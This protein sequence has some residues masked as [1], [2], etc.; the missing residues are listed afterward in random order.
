MNSTARTLQYVIVT[1]N[2][3]QIKYLDYYNDKV[4]S[5]PHFNTTTLTKGFNAVQVYIGIGNFDLQDMLSTSTGTTLIP[6]VN[7]IGVIN[8]YRRRVFSSTKLSLWGIF[9]SYSQIMATEMAIYGLTLFVQWLSE[10]LKTVEDYRDK[11]IFAGFATV[12]G[13][14]AFLAGIFGAI[15]GTSIIKIVFAIKPLSVY[16]LAHWL[17]KPA[18]REAC[19]AEYPRIQQDTKTSPEDRGLVSFMNDHLL[20]MDLSDP[21]KESKSSSPDDIETLSNAIMTPAVPLELPGSRIFLDNGPKREEQEIALLEI[22]S[23]HRG[24]GSEYTTSSL[25]ES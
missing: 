5:G 7:L 23:D 11:S 1:V 10:T 12:G 22:G 21:S 16:G 17:Q 8:L 9:D 15:F 19:V 25:S 4:S 3:T 6:G 2:F 18:L 13:L 20:D 14:S 24:G